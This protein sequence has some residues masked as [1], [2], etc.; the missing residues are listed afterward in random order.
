[1]HKI[2]KVLA[3][4]TEP[5]EL[6]E[7]NALTSHPKVNISKWKKLI[8]GSVIYTVNAV[9]L[10]LLKRRAQVAALRLLN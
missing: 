9:S 7:E 5:K 2:L 10:W 6:F 1:M 8:K 4:I 3:P